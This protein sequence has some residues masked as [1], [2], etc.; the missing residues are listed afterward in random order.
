M[1]FTLSHEGVHTA[2]IGT[3]H[4]ENAKANIAA[5]GKGPL[6]DDVV[7]KIRATFRSADPD[8]KWTGQT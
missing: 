2:I 7:K 5:A 4:P 6:P 3:T 8:G 1:R